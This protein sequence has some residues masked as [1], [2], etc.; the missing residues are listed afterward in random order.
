MRITTAETFRAL[1][2]TNQPLLLPNAWDV[3]SAAALANA[4]FAAIGT[5]GLGIAAAHGLPDAEG[6]TCEIG[7]A[8]V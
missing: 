5:T 3:A 8:H 1:H 2:H 4:G 6:L 7:R